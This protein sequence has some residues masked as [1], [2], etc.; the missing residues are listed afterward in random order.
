MALSDHPVVLTDGEVPG[1]AVAGVL[2]RSGPSRRHHREMPTVTEQR[3]YARRQPSGQG[4][5]WRRLYS[6]HIDE[7]PSLPFHSVPEAWRYRVATAPDRC[8]LRYFDGELSASQVDVATDALAVAFRTA[9]RTRATRGVQVPSADLHRKGRDRQDQARRP[10]LR[11]SLDRCIG[12]PLAELGE[13]TC[14]ES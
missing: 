12:Q 2:G 9:V 13:V 7:T 5:P 14:D 10:A 1:G 4:T 6:G 3:S 11:S 8:A